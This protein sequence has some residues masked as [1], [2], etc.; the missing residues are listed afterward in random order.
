M[1]RPKK[2]A[3]N[4]SDGRFEYKRVIGKNVDGKPLRKSFY[5]TISK[6]DAKKKADDYMRDLA[7]SEMTGANLIRSKATFEELAIDVLKIKKEKVRIGSYNTSWHVP[8]H[9]HLIPHFGRWQISNIT[10][11]DVDMYFISK[12]QYSKS[13]LSHHLFCIHE[14]FRYALDNKIIF[15]DPLVSYRLE[16]GTKKKEK[17]VYTEE[18]TNLI[19]EYCKLHEYGVDIDILLRHGLRQSELL[20]LKYS[21]FDFENKTAKIQRSVTP[22][23]RKDD[24]PYVIG[25]P[26]NDKS[27]RVIAVAAET[28]ELIK[29]NMKGEYVIN[30]PGDRP[31]CPQ[32]WYK[33]RYVKFMK[34]MQNYYKEKGVDIPILNVHELRHTRATIW[35]NK[36][37]NLFAICEQMG[38]TDLTMIRKI[39]GHPDIKLLRDDLGL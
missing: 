20:G 1:A 35:V 33:T 31:Y 7:L 17:H 21:D 36:G 2:Q 12:K 9:N 34:D 3:P 39:Y 16:F 26:K 10:R 4:R 5:S 28:I 22:T 29:K 13:T 27:K 32:N 23:Y 25:E 30:Y 38:W 18:E 37:V 8:M 11:A 14:V 24:D 19:L 6:D 15:S